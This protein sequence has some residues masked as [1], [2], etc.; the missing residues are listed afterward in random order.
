MS[1]CREYNIEVTMTDDISDFSHALTVSHQEIFIFFTHLL[2][3]AAILH[4]PNYSV[5]PYTAEQAI[6]VLRRVPRV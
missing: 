5:R 6:P 2:C 3:T 4:Y 1:L